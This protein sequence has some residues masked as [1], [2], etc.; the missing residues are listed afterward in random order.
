MG[1]FLALSEREHTHTHTVDHKQKKCL[2][3]IDE[4]HILQCY[5]QIND[6]QNIFLVAETFC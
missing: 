5:D 6:F 2:K 4:K 1:G 3:F